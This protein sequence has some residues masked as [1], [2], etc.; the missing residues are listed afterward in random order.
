MLWARR[1]LSL[2]LTFP[3]VMFH[4][5]GAGIEEDAKCWKLW[6]FS[7]AQSVKRLMKEDQA[8]IF[9]G[10]RNQRLS[11]QCQRYQFFFP[12]NP[13]RFKEKKNWNKILKHV[14]RDNSSIFI[15]HCHP[16][17]FTRSTIIQTTLAQTFLFGKLRE[18]SSVTMLPIFI[19][20]H[21]Y[22]YTYVLF[23][24]YHTSEIIWCLHMCV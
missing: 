14:I 10:L 15:A 11:P 17:I 21:V 2:V 4:S 16:Q 22:T 5:W 23:L 1:N 18:L 8:S 9:V 13:F 20:I 12:P 24:V 3:F 7:E 6:V 19:C